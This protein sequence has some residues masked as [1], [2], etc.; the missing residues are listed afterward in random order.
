MEGEL[1]IMMG[2]QSSRF[3]KLPRGRATII[4][5]HLVNHRKGPDWYVDASR[6]A[7][8]DG[9]EWG[10]AFKTMAEAF[11]R[12]IG[13]ETI[14]FAG[15]I[16]EQLV[17]PVQVFDVRIIGAGN[18]PRHADSTP[19]GGN[20][21]A[22]SWRP[23][24]SGAVS[25]KATVRVLQQG[26]SFEN[27]LFTMESATA[28][29]VEVV[30]DA[31]AGNAERDGS[32]CSVL[33]CRFAGAGIG[34]RS[35]VAGLFT[36]IAFNVLVEGNTFHDNT[37]AISGINGNAWQIVDNIFRGNTNHIVAAFQ[38]TQ[39]IGNIMGSFTTGSIDLTGGGGLNQVSLNVLS[40]TYADGAAYRKSNANDNWNGNFASTGV[41]AAVPA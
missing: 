5:G 8:G 27:I 20:L 13:G 36:E 10:Q 41:T 4:D 33:G 1:K 24:A 34:V 18:R 2:V 37:K 31:G 16:R 11:N 26:W 6:T 14:R 25:G 32:H 19:S 23:P 38:N 30:R 22:S 7:S 21:Y 17:T 29:G 40:G 35:G 15:T 28:A 12:L 9:T 39:I 3:R